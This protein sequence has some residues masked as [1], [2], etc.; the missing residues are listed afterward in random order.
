[1][2]VPAAGGAA[3]TAT[4]TVVGT[5]TPTVDGTI[6]VIV[7]A[8]FPFTVRLPPEPLGAWTV[9]PPYEAVIVLAAFEPGVN[10]TAQAELVESLAERGQVGGEKTSPATFDEIVITPAGLDF[11]PAGSTSA[12][13]AFTVVG[14]RTVTGF[15]VNV[16]VVV[17]ARGLTV[18]VTEDDEEAAWTVVAVK[19]AVSG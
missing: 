2:G 8:E 12:T 18:R 14:E 15:G 17:V 10:V 3:A 6:D 1:V 7:V 11:S 9:L 4:E 5:P 19:V 13:V 16:T